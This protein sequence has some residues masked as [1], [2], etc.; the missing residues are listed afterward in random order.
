MKKLS[1]F[2]AVAA[3][4]M[5]VVPWIAMAQA[6]D[7]SIFP[8][9]Y[10]G[11]LL[12]CTGVPPTT[13]GGSTTGEGTTGSGAPTSQCLSL[14]DLL[15]TIRNIIY[16]ALTFLIYVIV[17]IM[18]MVGGF[19]R[20]VSGGSSEKVSQ[21]NAY[22]KGAAIGLGVGLGAFLIVNVIYKV[23]N[24]TIEGQS[25][26]SVLNCTIPDSFKVNLTPQSGTT[27]P[28]TTP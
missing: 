12:S 5:T 22:F 28:A 16:F 13:G 14:C 26:W 2:V 18:I 25:S 27:P 20:M 6:G 23:L 24:P 17:P 8:T 19:I 10:W 9:G 11:P 1:V 15:M 4:F 3:V 7:P 21:S